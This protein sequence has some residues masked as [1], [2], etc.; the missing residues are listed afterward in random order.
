MALSGPLE[1]EVKVVQL[2]TQFFQRFLTLS[3]IES[4]H[5]EILAEFWI[6][7][8]NLHHKLRPIE[9]LKLKFDEKILEKT[10]FKIFSDQID[11][12]R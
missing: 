10:H 3:V 6:R 2:H 8:V 4:K 1:E 11:T 9:A 12:L 5:D 7:T